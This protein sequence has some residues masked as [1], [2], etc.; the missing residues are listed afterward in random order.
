[1]R[2]QFRSLS[3]L[4]KFAAKRGLV[5]RKTTVAKKNVYYKVLDRFGT[6]GVLGFFNE[7]PGTG[8]GLGSVDLQ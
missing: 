2:K 3:A 7:K 1:M 8:R 6:L 5:V 4:K